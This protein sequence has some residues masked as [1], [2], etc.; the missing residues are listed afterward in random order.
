MAKRLQDEHWPEEL[1]VRDLPF[2]LQDQG[3]N[4]LAVN[5]PGYERRPTELLHGRLEKESAPLHPNRAEM[6]LGIEGV[7]HPEA[8]NPFEDSPPNLVVEALVDQGLLQGSAVLAAVD[9][10]SSGDEAGRSIGVG[11]GKDHCCRHST[12]TGEKHLVE[13]APLTAVHLPDRR[14]A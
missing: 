13:P 11:I 7:A 14:G 4:P 6:R 3:V 5:V 1:E 2:R 8:P 9:E 12:R 10:G